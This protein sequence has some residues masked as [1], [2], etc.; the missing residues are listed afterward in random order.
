MDIETFS[1]I[2]KELVVPMFPGTEIRTLS[3]RSP[4]SNP[5]ALGETNRDVWL[6]LPGS[7]TK[8]LL[9]HRTQ[10]FADDD[11]AVLNKF[12]YVLKSISDQFKQP[13]FDDLLSTS[14]RRVVAKSVAD[15]DEMVLRLLDQAQSWA[16]QTYEGRPI[17]AAIGIN[18]E[19]TG[20][21][22]V[23]LQDIVR[24]DYGP[25]L[26]NGTDTLVE[27][28]KSGYVVAHHWLTKSDSGVI[29]PLPWA[30]IASWSS[31]GRIVVALNRIGETLVF[32][33]K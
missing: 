12:I 24:E 32:S 6:R 11:L 10:Q 33:N 9:L 31:G 4:R 30:P 16:E 29:C 8:A 15:D 25:V 3:E 23:L 26:T 1:G 18:P 2:V 28:S 20:T 13:F 21:S 5:V 22:Q 17:A 19:A 27:V 7:G 14:I